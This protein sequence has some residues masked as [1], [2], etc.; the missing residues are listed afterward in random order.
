[1]TIRNEKKSDTNLH[2]IVSPTINTG[3]SAFVGVP[4]NDDK[5]FESEIIKKPEDFEKVK[6]KVESILGPID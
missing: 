1:M 4:F 5:F 2:R 6:K 3:V